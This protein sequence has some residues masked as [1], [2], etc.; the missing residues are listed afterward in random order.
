MST[1]RQSSDS[2]NER[3]NSRANEEL[4]KDRIRE[5]E[6]EVSS[7]KK[8][9]DELR[10]AKNTTILKRERE[11]VNI[12]AP[13]MGR[14][15]S[16]PSNDPRIRELEIELREWKQ[17]STEAERKLSELEKKYQNELKELREK[18]SFEVENLKKQQ[19]QNEN[20]SDECRFHEMEIHTLKTQVKL[21]EEDKSVLQVQN[22]EHVSR[23][24]ELIT[25]LSV[26]EAKWCEM[27]ETY[28]RK[29]QESFGEKYR[30]WMAK[31]ESKLME[32]TQANA[33]LRSLV[34][35]PQGPDPTGQDPD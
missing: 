14:R 1:R 32:L 31:T 25:E 24:E 27:E 22:Q 4:L 11:V 2:I 10:K 12:Q 21:L 13:N 29:V 34:R 18:F 19:Q 26:K 7:L 6:T 30:E 20:N 23:I 15:D 28:K 8:R 35:K 5:L 33:L 16:K 17:K 9:L 3:R